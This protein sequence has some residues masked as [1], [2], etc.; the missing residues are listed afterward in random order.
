MRRAVVLA[1]LMAIPAYGGQEPTRVYDG[2]PRP[3]SE[4]AV[5]FIEKGRLEKLDG[6]KPPKGREL[7]LPPGRHVFRV[8]VDIPVGDSWVKTPAF[9]REM[10]LV[11]GHCYAIRTREPRM[12]VF[13]PQVIERPCPG[14]AT[15]NLALKKAAAASSEQE[16][17]FAAKHAV[18]GDHRTRW[19]SVFEDDQ[20]L[21]VDLGSVQPIGSVTPWWEAAHALEY[22]VDLSSDGIAWETAV[23]ITDG[24]KGS[25]TLPLAG[26]SRARYVRV[27]GRTRATPWGFSLWELEVHPPDAAAA[28]AAPSE[29]SAT[30]E[31]MVEERPLKLEP[32]PAP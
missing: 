19:S 14:D 1:T 2:P 7:H 5:V 4:V 13:A 29:A 26:G 6:L 23:T 27:F 17:R 8:S 31:P 3:L 30:P 20:F 10:E 32:E 28:P 18:D 16:K 21:S 12:G 25:T 15:V 11:A 24:K 22:S 9:P